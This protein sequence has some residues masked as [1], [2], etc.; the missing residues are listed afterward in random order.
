MIIRKGFNER[1][2]RYVQLTEEEEAFLI[3]YKVFCLFTRRLLCLNAE[4]K[5]IRKTALHESRCYVRYALQDSM[6]NNNGKVQQCI[7]SDED[8]VHLLYDLSLSL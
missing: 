6:D 3:E 1:I 2:K 4:V 8:K 5:L 7:S